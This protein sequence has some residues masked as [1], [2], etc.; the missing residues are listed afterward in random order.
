[1][2]NKYLA[3]EDAPFGSEVWD[4]LDAAMKEAAKSQLVGRR[5]LHVEGPFGLG[6]KAVP[7]RDAETESG[8]MASEVLPVPLIQERF[9]LGARDWA[10]Y[11]REG[12]SL[13]TGPVA[14][15]AMACAR[16]ED[17]LIF[18]GTLGVPGLLTVEGVNKI[19][20]PAWDEVGTAANDI[21]QAITTLDSAGFHGP[22]ALALAPDRYNL[23]LR[24]YPRGPFSEMEHV[25]KVVTEGVFKA[26]ILESGGVLLASGRRYASIVLGQDMTIGFIGPA[27]DQI[28]FLISESLTVRILQPKAI[29]VLMG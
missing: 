1:M 5:L 10:D 9:T 2:A 20:L 12:V 28:E 25:K 23:L 21:I 27:G 17:G 11:E 26:P 29:C 18:N 19:N 7:L 8:L 14:E 16:Q 24:L 15:A 13:D 4:V 3:R 22:Y 6:L